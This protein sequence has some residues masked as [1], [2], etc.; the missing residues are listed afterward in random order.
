MC[1]WII[2]FARC[3]LQ[4]KDPSSLIETRVVLHSY[5]YLHLMIQRE[6]ERHIKHDEVK[7]FDEGD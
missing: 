4:T 5:N 3:E 7:N 6:K 1:F 2:S